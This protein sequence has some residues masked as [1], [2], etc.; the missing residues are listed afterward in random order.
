M[1]VTILATIFV[2]SVAEAEAE[3]EAAVVVRVTDFAAAIPCFR[4]QLV[5]VA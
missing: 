2:R 1:S 3:A 4:G 5:Q